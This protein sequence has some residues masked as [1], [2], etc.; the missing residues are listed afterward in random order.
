MF[1]FYGLFYHHHGYQIRRCILIRP[2][3]W[4]M[5]NSDYSEQASLFHWSIIHWRCS[6]VQCR[7]SCGWRFVNRSNWEGCSAYSNIQQC[8]LYCVLRS[9]FTWT[10]IVLVCQPSHCL[11]PILLN[12]VGQTPKSFFRDN[13]LTPNAMTS[14]AGF[15]CMHPLCRSANKGRLQIIDDSCTFGNTRSEPS[16]H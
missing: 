4:W 16:G 12:Q 8:S 15:T 13:A 2:S 14:T 5:T 3:I 1:I 6:W 9:N 7:R 10:C 11:A